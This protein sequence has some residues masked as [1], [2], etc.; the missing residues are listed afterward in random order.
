MLAFSYIC[1]GIALIAIVIGV[2]IS[3]VH[4]EYDKTNST[5]KNIRFRTSIG[6]GIGF[7]ILTF[8]LFIVTSIHEPIDYKEPTISTT[9]T[10]LISVSDVN[11]IEGNIQGSGLHTYGYLT[12][13]NSY[14]YYYQ[15]ED[16][17]IIQ[18]AI[19]VDS[20]VIYYIESGEK[21]YLET[22]TTTRYCYMNKYNHKVEIIEEYL[23]NLYIP[24][25]SILDGN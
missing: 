20:T 10:D 23:Y 6:I 22:I 25:G 5:K 2:V 15:R 8:I 14:Q 7:L 12:A 24:K 11:N 17:G 16:G 1:F 13:K 3:F 18:G 21:P 9:K 19:P 4:P